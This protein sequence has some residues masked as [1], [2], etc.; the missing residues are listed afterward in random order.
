VSSLLEE[1]ADI[2]AEQTLSPLQMFIAFSALSLSGFGGVMP[3]AYRALVERRKWLSGP[4]FAA[5]VGVAQVLPGPTICN[6]AVMVGMRKSGRLGGAT[7][8]LGMV[9][10]PMVIVLLLGILYEHVGSAQP[11]QAALR[12]MSA[13][14]AGLIFATAVKMAR[15]VFIAAKSTPLRRLVMLLWCGLAFGGVGILRINLAIVVAILAPLAIG[16]EWWARNE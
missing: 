1:T 3:F 16:F 7:A 15:T 12:G 5:L 14:A 10:G 9:L 11:V 4:D 2:A 13:V 6:M 8:L